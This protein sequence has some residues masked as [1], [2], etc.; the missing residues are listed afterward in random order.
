[1]ASSV[2]GALRVNLGLDSAEFQKGAKKVQ[3]PLASLKK[4]MLAFGAVAV[5]AGAAIGA[6]A[7]R[8]AAD[9]DKTAKA[10]RRLG[11]SFASFRAMELAA[12]EA[13]VAMATLTDAVQT[14]DREIARGSK[15]AIEALAQLGLAAK[16]LEGLSADQ[17]LALLADRIKA[18]GLSS[19][20]TSAVL[21]DLGVRNKEMVLALASGGDMFRSAASDI[22]DYGL[23]LSDVD[24]STIEEAND[25]IGRLGMIGKYVGQ[26]LALVLVPALGKLAQVMTDSLR[27]GGLLRG[28]IDGLVLALRGLVGIVNLVV[29]AFSGLRTL[30]DIPERLVRALFSLGPTALQ[31]QRATDALTLAIGDELRQIGALSQEMSGGVTMSKNMAQ[32]K[33]D[34]ARAHWA[35]LE[36]MRQESIQLAKSSSEYKAA[37]SEVSRLTMAI[38]Q[39][40]AGEWNK[41]ALGE[42]P[43]QVNALVEEL[44]RAQQ[45]QAALIADSGKIS[46]EYVA[47]QENIA[48]IQTAIENATGESVTFSGT[49]V[50]AD[51]IAARLAGTAN[52]ISFGAANAGA[53]EL[54]RKLGISLEMAQRLAGLGLG[55][56]AIAAGDGRGSQREGVQ[57]A[58]AFH[59]EQWEAQNNA[60]LS[61]LRNVA[62]GVPS[63]GGGGGGGGGGA[64]KEA[65]SIQDVVKAL[66]DEAAAIGLSEKARRIR[67]EL[68]KAG[69]ELYSQEGQQIADLIEDIDRLEGKERLI[70]RISTAIGDAIGK[71]KSWGEAMVNLKNAFISAI[72]DMASKLISSGIKDLLSSVLGGI[73][74]GGGGGWI[75]KLLGGLIG[76]N[77]NGT[78]NWRGGLS[79]VNERGGEIM[80]LPN[81]TQIIPHDISKRMADGAGGMAVVELRLSDDLDARI[82]DGATTVAVRVTQ[83]GIQSYDRGLPGRVHGINSDPRRRS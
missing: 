6:M 82:V 11:T 61:A 2:I 37:Q 26:Q 53:A 44:Y 67:T 66:K 68:Q 70:D 58:L 55:D 4:Q 20:Q 42:L 25:R 83:Q 39:A 19:G 57:D 30:L 43:V 9:I 27:E 36:A 1:M 76:G 69:V 49:L 18:L 52:S 28:V 81:G 5:A 31:A 50:T 41:D 73:G 13:G 62:L 51:D 33:L 63:S 17:K 21:Q 46:P 45:A 3:A 48:R 12:E 72:G 8:G 22:K 23:A 78:P 79:A 14:M 47:A 77:A 60:R 74:G 35:S 75:G 64:A 32:A 40:L 80:N 29:A 24:A 65:N 71:A 34:Q 15:P 7:M 38:Q 10:A 56:A 59:R 16:D 54:A